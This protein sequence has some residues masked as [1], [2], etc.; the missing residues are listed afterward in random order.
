[1]VTLLPP[2]GRC[3]NY[4]FLLA[5]QLADV[6]RRLQEPQTDAAPDHHNLLRE[7][8]QVFRDDAVEYTRVCAWLDVSAPVSTFVPIM[9]SAGPGVVHAGG[10]TWLC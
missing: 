6:G 1:M 7:A 4:T 3:H 8:Q 2:N 5:L 10:I 9:C